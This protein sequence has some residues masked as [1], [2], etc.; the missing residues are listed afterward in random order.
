MV[1]DKGEG[2]SVAW[3]SVL[4]PLGGQKGRL[5]KRGDAETRGSGSRLSPTG[6][7]RSVVPEV[8]RSSAQKGQAPRWAPQNMLPTRVLGLLK[9]NRN[10]SE[11]K[12]S[13]G[14][15]GTPAAVERGWGRVVRTNNRFLC[16]PAPHCGFDLYFPD[17]EWCLAPSHILVGHLYIFGEISVEV[18]CLR[19]AGGSSRPLKGPQPGLTLLFFM[20]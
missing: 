11:A 13:Q 8:P 12:F 1:R 18:L 7:L 3:M 6:K 16:L 5:T 17:D 9:I 10:W 15:T 14:F 4:R 20:L 2:R 19:G